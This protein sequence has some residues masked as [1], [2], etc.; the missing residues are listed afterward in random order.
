[1]GV[2]RWTAKGLKIVGEI[3]DSDNVE[4]WIKN[5]GQEFLKKKLI[6][7]PGK[8]FAGQARAEH[9][10]RK[11][12]EESLGGSEAFRAA[13]SATLEQLPT[14]LLVIANE[15][16]KANISDLMIS[17]NLQ[18]NCI[19]VCPRGLVTHLYMQHVLSSLKDAAGLHKYTGLRD[20]L[21][22]QAAVASEESFFSKKGGSPRLGQRGEILATDRDYP[23]SFL[24]RNGHYYVGLTG[25]LSKGLTDKPTAKEFRAFCSDNLGAIKVR[26][27]KLT[28]QDIERL[29]NE[30]SRTFGVG[31]K[32][33]AQTA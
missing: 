17:D 28:L 14:V 20:V 11:E 29:S 19:V 33:M 9:G 1:M 16:V 23:W 30:L 24:Q 13:L 4:K 25:Q 15:I 18:R 32:P 7:M 8:W 6:D 27:G 26:I 3:L 21:L 2:I 12:I 5:Q 31:P 22:N 10:L